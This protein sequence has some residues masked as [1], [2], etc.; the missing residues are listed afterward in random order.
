MGDN[1]ERMNDKVDIS[2]I[3][4][5]DAA[6]QERH[7]KRMFAIVLTVLIGWLLT[8]GAFL[9]Y[10]SL[11]VD[12]YTTEQTVDDIDDSSITQIGGDNYG[13]SYDKDNTQEKSSE[14]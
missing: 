12:E 6:R 3:I 13:E 14:K 5:N 1:S 11:P 8:I 4:E 9:L 10:L 2:V 7:N